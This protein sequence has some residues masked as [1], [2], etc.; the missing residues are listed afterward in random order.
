MTQTNWA[1]K[2]T[3]SFAPQHHELEDS[4]GSRALA[5]V[6]VLVEAKE[7]AA[8]PTWD[9][10]GEDVTNAGGGFRITDEK[11]PA[12]GCFGCGDLRERRPRGLSADTGLLTRPSTSPP[13]TPSSTSHSRH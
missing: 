5:G 12:R 4:Y 8:D 6:K 13:A 2:G 1:I 3:L 11:D 10:W 7:I 9:D